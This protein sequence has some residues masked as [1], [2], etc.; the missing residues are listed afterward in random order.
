MTNTLRVRKIYEKGDYFILHDKSQS[1]AAWLDILHSDL[2]NLIKDVTLFSTLHLSKIAI[3]LIL[4][5][6]IH[7]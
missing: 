1:A 4:N 3:L 6:N 2:L 5:S 7:Q